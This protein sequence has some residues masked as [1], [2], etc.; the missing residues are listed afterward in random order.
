[1]YKYVL[2]VRV[3]LTAIVLSI[4]GCTSL[5]GTR[6]QGAK[7]AQ[8]SNE[9]LQPLDAATIYKNSHYSVVSIKTHRQNKLVNEEYENTLQALKDLCG[10]DVA[11]CISAVDETS[12]AISIGTGFFIN[13]TGMTLTA[14]HVVDG[15]DKIYLRLANYQTIQ[16][17][18]V[19]KDIQTD[20][21]IL[22]PVSSI[23]TVA[24]ALGNSTQLNVGD[25]LISIGAPFGIAGSLTSGQVSGI[26]RRLSD[27]GE[28]P[29]LQ[30]DIVINSGNSGGPLFDQRGRVVAITS[31]T[32]TSTG[33]YTG[34]AFATPIELAMLVVDDLLSGHPL[35]RG[36]IGATL[37]D[38]PSEMIDLIA[39]PDSLGV[40]IV[41]VTK[42]GLFAA[43]GLSA[44]D[45]VR[46]FDGK[47]V[48]HAGQLSR[49]LFEFPRE[50][51]A[52]LTVWRPGQT[53]DRTVLMP[54]KI[55]N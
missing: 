8:N 32:L 41:S 55:S 37:A 24:L 51:Q 35:S 14:A 1:M 45:I 23:K 15:A 54:I 4:C 49:L 16:A 36:R 22:K 33:E 28:I 26:D 31:R 25:Q 52:Q 29:Y 40:F 50:K 48:T 47:A 38:V 42:D 21:A 11:D 6:T 17:I 10:R 39:A 46:S 13:D 20:L 30:S 3:I 19:G 18:V 53:I 2:V 27:I 9:R 44:G 5:E 12:I 7:N 34:I 43:A